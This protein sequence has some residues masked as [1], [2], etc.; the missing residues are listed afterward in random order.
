MIGIFFQLT[1][2]SYNQSGD[3][4]TLLQSS[5]RIQLLWAKQAVKLEKRILQNT[6]NKKVDPLTSKF[7]EDVD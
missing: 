2:S 4:K 3:T 5:F 7:I 1:L 6:P